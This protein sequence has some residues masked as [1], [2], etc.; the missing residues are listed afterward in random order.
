M[1]ITI[2]GLRIVAVVAAIG[3]GLPDLDHGVVERISFAIEHTADQPQVLAFG[4]R[5]GD[6]W[7][8]IQAGAAKMKIRTS[9]L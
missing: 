4:L 2:A 9:R 7:H 5:T 1:R 3:I 6:A 8:R